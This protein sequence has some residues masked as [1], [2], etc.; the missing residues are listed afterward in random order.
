MIQLTQTQK[1]QIKAVY[2]R[3]IVRELYAKSL[4]TREQY[5][6]LMTK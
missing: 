2:R 5:R 1:Q 4:L 3:G 6:A